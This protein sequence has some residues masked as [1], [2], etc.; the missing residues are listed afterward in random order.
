M[1]IVS[2]EIQ[3]SW[4]WNFVTQLRERLDLNKCLISKAR[5]RLVKMIS[6]W[7]YWC[8]RR[9]NSYICSIFVPEIND[10]RNSRIAPSSFFFF[11]LLLWNFKT[12]SL[13]YRYMGNT[14][15]GDSSWEGAWYR[16]VWGERAL[17]IFVACI[18]VILT[19][20]V[21]S[22]VETFSYYLRDRSNA[23]AIASFV[24]W[25]ENLLPVF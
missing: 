16:P 20:S 3:C 9:T 6:K 23:I 25:L 22:W 12:N 13:A 11:Y 24:D 14:Q 8:I 17:K 15:V 5:E 1:V 18:F 19:L 7:I 10:I 2:C 21:Q 4:N